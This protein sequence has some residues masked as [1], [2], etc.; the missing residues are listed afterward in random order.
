MADDG[1]PNEKLEELAEDEAVS[2]GDVVD[3]VVDVEV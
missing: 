2:E 3:R 1:V